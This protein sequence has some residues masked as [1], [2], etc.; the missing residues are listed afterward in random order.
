MRFRIRSI[1]FFFF[2]KRVY[3]DLLEGYDDN[4][5]LINEVSFN[6]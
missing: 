2:E 4:D 5:G 1:G 6:K 3:D